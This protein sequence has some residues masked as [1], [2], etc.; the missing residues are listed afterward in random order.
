MTAANRPRG[1]QSVFTQAIADEICTAL[2]AGKSLNAICKAE[3]MPSE[4]A[5][6]AWAMDDREGFA[7]KYARAR[8]LG[9]DCIA[10]EIIDIADTPKTGTKTVSKATGIEITEGDMV[11]HRRLQIESRKWYLSKL[12]PK[13]YGEKLAI[14]GADDLP[15]IKGMPDEQ[16]L[17]RIKALQEKLT[18]KSE[19]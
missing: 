17:A 11:E 12:A 14:G 7:A 8:D 4:H 5:V 15:P 19:D 3:G 18:P 13:R 1:G 2:S 9:L 16:L 10:Q 6:R